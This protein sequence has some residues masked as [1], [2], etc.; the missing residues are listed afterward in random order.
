MLPKDENL[1]L[2]PVASSPAAQQEGQRSRGDRSCPGAFDAVTE[3]DPTWP[4]F[5]SPNSRQSRRRRKNHVDTSSEDAIIDVM[6]A[7]IALDF[8]T[9][10]LDRRLRELNLYFKLVLLPT[11]LFCVEPSI[12][13]ESACRLNL[14]S[15]W[16]AGSRID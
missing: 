15:V 8:V 16:F 7:L 2:L 14:I 13:E 11:D 9:A 4:R 3:Q 10:F 1:L 5:I 12:E 6:L